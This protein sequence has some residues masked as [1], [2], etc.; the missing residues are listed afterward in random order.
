MSFEIDRNHKVTVAIERMFSIVRN[1]AIQH[2]FTNEDEHFHIRN[3]ADFPDLNYDDSGDRWLERRH[4]KRLAGE[5]I[6]Y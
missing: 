1:E 6:Y 5:R 3:H 4:E 2:L